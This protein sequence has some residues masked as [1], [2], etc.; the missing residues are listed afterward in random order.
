MG[1]GAGPNPAGCWSR[2]NYLFSKSTSCQHKTSLDL[3]GRARGQPGFGHDIT[4]CPIS[5]PP[6]AEEEDDNDVGGGG[7]G[8]GGGK[9]GG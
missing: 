3:R 5:C 1:R 2:R 7:E 9:G 8:A 4:S 6:L